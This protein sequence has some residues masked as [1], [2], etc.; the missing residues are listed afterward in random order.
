MSQG[1]AFAIKAVPSGRSIA[2]IAMKPLARP[3]W[4]SER[5][6]PFKASGLEVDGKTIA[7]TDIGDGPVLLL[8]HTGLWSF[9]WR[10]VI[11]RLAA[12]FRCV[13]F[14]APG[15]GQSD[16]LAASEISLERASRAVAAVIGGLDLRELTLVFHDLGG[17]AAIAGAARTSERVRGL[18]GVNTF[19]WKPSGAMFRGMLKLMG[20]APM[21][22]FDA[23]T[24]LL[25]KISASSFGV[26]RHLDGQ[27]REAF[28]AGIGPDGL[29]AFHR[30]MRDARVCE[31]IY[32]QAG[33]A[34]AGPFKT[35]PLLTIFGERNDPL[36]FQPRWKE[37]FPEARQ[38]VVPKG[39]HFPMCDDPDLVANAIR[40]WHRERVI[41][42]LQ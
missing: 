4:L 22:E 13:T 18:V 12:D 14:D 32:E 9:V 15:T 26:G 31:S 40:S 6:W 24:G 37:M 20:S 21:R 11:T 35:L 36:G 5:V 29:R 1:S 8:V 2:S 28:R 30:Y 16:R 25:A 23:A 42:V 38:V 19:G 41:G 39:N 34:L 27:S 17:P 10:D 33:S 3:S 7:V